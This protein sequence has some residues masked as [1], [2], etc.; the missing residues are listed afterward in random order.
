MRIPLPH[1]DYVWQPVSKL[2]VI[3]WGLALAYATYLYRPGGVYF[4]GNAHLVSHEA[5]HLLFSHTGNQTITIFMGTGLELLVPLLLA[6]SFA[7]RGHT[8]GTAVCAW[9]FFNA[10]IG[11]G[12]YMADARDKALPLVSPGVASDEVE[13]HDWEYIFNWLGVIKHDEQIGNVTR[14]LGYLGMIAVILWLVYMWKKS[15][16]GTLNED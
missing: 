5:G 11:I 3:G 1:P 15:E 7:W 2:A 4:L 12:I 16:D 6:L 13:G 9:G 14:Y 10:F 8:T